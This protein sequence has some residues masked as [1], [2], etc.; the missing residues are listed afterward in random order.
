MFLGRI[1]LGEARALNVRF[2]I[3]A[4]SAAF[5]LLDEIFERPDL[6]AVILRGVA[7][8]NDLE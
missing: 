2:P 4:F 3:I 6:R 8:Q 1:E 5:L 7:D